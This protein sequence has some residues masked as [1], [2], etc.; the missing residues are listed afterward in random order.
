[1]LEG[2]LVEAV[3][4][5][6]HQVGAAAADEGQAV[7]VLCEADEAAAAVARDGCRVAGD[8]RRLAGEERLGAG[9][10]RRRD[11]APAVRARGVDED[12]GDDRDGGARLDRVGGPG[13]A[14]PERPALRR[15]RRG[16][17]VLVGE[18]AVVLRRGADRRHQDL[19]AV[20]LDRE[21]LLPRR[22]AE[23]G[24]VAR[25]R[26]VLAERR[27]LGL[28]AA[29][30][31]PAADEEVDLEPERGQ[32]RQPHRDPRPDVVGEEE[33]ADDERQ[34]RDAQSPEQPGATAELLLEVGGLLDG[35]V[36]L[37]RR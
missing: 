15:R 7:R 21:G 2:E 10:I 34:H 14:L 19:L 8:L 3:A 33:V 36:H 18:P 35:F 25:L 23:V 24:Q 13:M 4:E 32:E 30:L 12:P 31:Q 16:R 9:L 1:M 29:G 37:R 17:L 26:P 6:R 11:R 20:V 27:R 28:A 22:A 5:T